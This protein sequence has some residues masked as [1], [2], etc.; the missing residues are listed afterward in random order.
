MSQQPFDQGLL[1]FTRYR[2]SKE[3]TRAIRNLRII[4]LVV[5]NGCHGTKAQLQQ[6]VKNNTFDHRTSRALVFRGIGLVMA[7]STMD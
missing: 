1:R 5:A 2:S 3:N 6:R 7:Q 4:A